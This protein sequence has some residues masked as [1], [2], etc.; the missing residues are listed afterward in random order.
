[1][2]SSARSLAGRLSDFIHSLLHPVKK[3]K[4]AEYFDEKWKT[5]ISA[6]S[7]FISPGDTVMDLGCGKMWLKEFLP[8]SCLY[9]PVDYTD[10]GAGTIICDFNSK[11]FPEQKAST[12]FISGCLEYIKPYDWFIS[13]SC[14]ASSKIILSYCCIDEFP[15]LSE[16]R[17][18]NWVNHLS[19]DELQSLF[20]KHNFRLTHMAKIPSRD[21]IMVFEKI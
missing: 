15:S 5:R 4:E 1:M 18:N 12:I 13:S 10:R 21:R 3:W 17:T 14:T 16:R 11:E 9:I 2:A 19:A 8:P 20:S 7:A 6:M